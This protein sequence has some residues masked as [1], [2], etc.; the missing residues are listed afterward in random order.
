M[1]VK[2]LVLFCAIFIST[3]Y[4]EA[5]DGLF[6]RFS[7]G[8]G[9]YKEGSVLHKTGFTTPAKNHAIG[10]GFGKKYAI[11]FSDFGGLI[12][13][14]V[15]DYDYIN[16]DALGLGF[17]YFLPYNTYLTLSGAYGKVTLAHNWK[18]VVNDGRQDGYAI[19]LS[20]NKEWF[21]SKRWGL[22]IGTQAFYFKTNGIEYKFIHFGI[23]GAVVFH[24]AP[25]L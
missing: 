12:Q 19:N 11:E 14:K 3:G 2:L 25:V 5:R 20:L 22:G 8:T 6:I 4:A 13:N 16:V 9:L 17:N 18:E 7:V 24:L 21:I 15:G 23:N 1:H 10:W